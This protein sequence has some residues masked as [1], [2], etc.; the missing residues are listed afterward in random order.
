MDNENY[1]DHPDFL[2][3]GEITD[4]TH[5]FYGKTNEERELEIIKLYGQCEDYPDTTSAIN[6]WNVENV[7]IYGGQIKGRFNYARDQKRIINK[8]KYGEI[9]LTNVEKNYRKHQLN[10]ANEL[11]PVKKHHEFESGI[12]ICWGRNI[13][14][15]N[16]QI[17]DI[18]GDAIGVT[19]LG[20]SGQINSSSDNVV[21]QNCLFHDCRR[22]G[23]SLCGCSNTFVSNCKIH[24]I[25]GKMPQGGID[26]EPDSPGHRYWGIAKNITIENCDI[27]KCGGAW[28]VEGT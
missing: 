19:Y 20:G 18:K 27:F 21:I 4:P 8:E 6:I 22:Q 23:A 10:W 26:I 2:E 25:K 11:V 7:N 1:F 3:M 5:E 16:V 28:N 17:S 9:D 15:D 12:G 13:V 24:D 14:I